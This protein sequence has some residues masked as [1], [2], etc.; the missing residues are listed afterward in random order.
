MAKF[1]GRVS[2][3]PGGKGRKAPDPRLSKAISIASPSAFKA[4][5]GRVKMLKGISAQ[6]KKAALSN[7]RNIAGA[8]LKRKTL[9]AKERK[10]STAIKNTR[11]P[12]L[13]SLGA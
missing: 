3:F 1:K 5:I 6:R 2:I 9:S 8:Q 11:L 13:K 7:A 12:S 10:Q 4:S